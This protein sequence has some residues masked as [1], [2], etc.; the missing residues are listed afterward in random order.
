MTYSI[1]TSPCLTAPAQM[2]VG[3]MIPS[4]CEFTGFI[5][6]PATLMA[7]FWLIGRRRRPN[8]AGHA[9]LVLAVAVT[10]ALSVLWVVG[11][12]DEW[13]FEPKTDE[14]GACVLVGNLPEVREYTDARIANGP[15][16]DVRPEASTD[17]KPPLHT[18]Q[19]AVGE[20]DGDKVHE[21]MKS[22]WRHFR[23]NLVNSDVSVLADPAASRWVTLEE[24]R[25]SRPATQSESR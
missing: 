11:G 1:L 4:L 24:W 21:G 6:I 23:V 8:S 15:Q 12:I 22:I 2:D 9:A 17:P 5:I 25:R 16:R 7:W 10:S 13:F 20:L 14:V 3:P 19:L 18:I